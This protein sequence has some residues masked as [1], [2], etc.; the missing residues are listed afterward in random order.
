MTTN[1]RHCV[2]EEKKC[3]RIFPDSFVRAAN[4]YDRVYYCPAAATLRGVLKKYR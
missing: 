4:R 3:K 2:A 1:V